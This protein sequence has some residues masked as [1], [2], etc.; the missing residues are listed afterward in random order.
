MERMLLSYPSLWQG[1]RDDLTVIMTDSMTM[2][3]VAPTPQGISPVKSYYIH[4]RMIASRPRGAPKHETIALL[5]RQ[6]HR[7]ALACMNISPPFL[8]RALSAASPDP[9]LGWEPQNSSS[10]PK[11]R[12]CHGSYP[13]R[14]VE[15]PS[16][17]SKR[18]FRAAVFQQRM[19]LT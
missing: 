5:A 10:A 16:I 15:S 6:Y 11:L 14:R 3:L 1:G 12:C 4:L 8:L 19:S 18:C 7:R 17:A 2:V 9:F 13:N